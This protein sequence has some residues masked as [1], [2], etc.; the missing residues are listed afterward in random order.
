MKKLKMKNT[1][2][3]PLAV[4]VIA[5]TIGCNL[6]GSSSKNETTYAGNWAGTAC[7]R[8]LT[9]TINQDGNNLSG[10]YTLD[11]PEFTENFQGTVA[12]GTPPAKAVLTAGDGRKFEITFTAYNRF[13]GTFFNPGP[14]CAV[15]AAK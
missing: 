15:S 3:L 1:L 4:I 9:M 12:E 11:N 5:F 10:T 8:N 7:G 13:E 14:V 2:A 6:S